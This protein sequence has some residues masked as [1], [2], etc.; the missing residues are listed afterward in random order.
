MSPQQNQPD[1]EPLPE[2]FY[3]ACDPVFNGMPEIKRPF[4]YGDNIVATDRSIFVAANKNRYDVSGILDHTKNKKISGVGRVLQEIVSTECEKPYSPV[5]IPE[6]NIRFMEYKSR[7]NHRCPEC[8]GSGKVETHTKYSTYKNTCLRCE[9]TGIGLRIE[10]V[11]EAVCIDG[12]RLNPC[13]IYLIN[14]ADKYHIKEKLQLFFRMS[15]IRGMI[16]GYRF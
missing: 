7:T 13:Y 15:D 9:G 14:K 10:H 12:L 5:E 3:H 8:E 1:L 11:N 2:I 4:V 16:C 6:D